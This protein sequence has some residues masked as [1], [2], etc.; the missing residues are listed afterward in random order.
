MAQQIDFNAIVSDAE[1]IEKVWVK[2]PSMTL[3]SDSDPKNPKVTHVE[4]QKTITDVEGF[5]SRIEDLRS[6][7]DDLL[8][9]RNE[10]ARALSQLNT[11]ALSAIRG[12][13]GPDST[14]YEQAGG[15]RSSERKKPVRKGST[16]AK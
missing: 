8:N 10:S 4:Y 12:I 7:I 6:Q 15:T 13:F 3:G 9:K 14:E 11:R 5:S 2:N 1:K 16:S